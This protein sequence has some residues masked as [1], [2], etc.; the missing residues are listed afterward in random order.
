MNISSY[1]AY[2]VTSVGISWAWFG[3]LLVFFLII[4]FLLV[5]TSNFFLS[6]SVSGFCVTILSVLVRGAS[7]HNSSNVL[8]DKAT[9][10]FFILTLVGIFLTILTGGEE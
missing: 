5:Q 10:L 6:V 9:A 4:V 2:P 7:I 1:L 3:I 8:G